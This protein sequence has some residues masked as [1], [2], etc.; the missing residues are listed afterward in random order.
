MLG[1]E[2]MQIWVGGVVWA[3]G[4]KREGSSD[5]PAFAVVLPSTVPTAGAR[6]NQGRDE[7]AGSRGCVC[8]DRGRREPEPTGYCL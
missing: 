6:A 1:L 2:M 4:S 5:G 8:V 3:F 7:P